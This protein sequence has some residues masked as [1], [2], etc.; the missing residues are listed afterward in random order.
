[1]YVCV[2]LLLLRCCCC[3][4]CIRRLYDNSGVKVDPWG[5]CG[6]DLMQA[7]TNGVIYKLIASSTVFQ[8][9][10]NEHY[11]RAWMNVGDI[12]NIF[13]NM[14]WCPIKSGGVDEMEKQ[15]LRHFLNRSSNQNR[16]PSQPANVLL[17]EHTVS[18]IRTFL[19]ELKLFELD[20]GDPPSERVL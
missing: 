1:M 2:A 3:C 16:N 20:I 15:V 6:L 19:L 7:I 5:K 8:N 12:L 10:H 11:S 18:M 13:R 17:T 14:V 4:C 9:P